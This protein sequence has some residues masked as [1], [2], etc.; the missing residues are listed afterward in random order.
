MCLHE[1]CVNYETV[2]CMLSQL[3]KYALSLLAKT[4]DRRLLRAKPSEII[5]MSYYNLHHTAKNITGTFFFAIHKEKSF[6]SNVR[7]VTVLSLQA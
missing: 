7:D 1:G 4:F 6:D 3:Q 2:Q 5:Y